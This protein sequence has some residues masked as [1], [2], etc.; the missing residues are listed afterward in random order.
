[1]HLQGA[2]PSTAP[3]NLVTSRKW[4]QSGVEPPVLSQPRDAEHVKTQP[5][6]LRVAPITA[7][8]RLLEPLQNLQNYTC[9]GKKHCLP[10]WSMEPFFCSK[11][12]PGCPAKPIL[13]WGSGSH[14]FLETHTVRFNAPWTKRLGAAYGKEKHPKPNKTPVIVKHVLYIIKV[15]FRF[16]SL[17]YN[18]AFQRSL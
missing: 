17:H 13:T 12:T 1:M 5:S 6:T 3:T 2:V 16:Y 7:A 9:V 10:A 4:T 8:I 18:R 11:R 15:H 14:R